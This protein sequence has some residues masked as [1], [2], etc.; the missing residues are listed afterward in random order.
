M[1]RN[2]FLIDFVNHRL[3][4]NFSSS[5]NI[6]ISSDIEILVSSCFSSCK[7][8]SSIS[9][10][11][12]SRLNRKN[13][14]HCHFHHFNRLSIDANHERFTMRSDFLID[15]LDH[16]LVALRNAGNGA[17]R[18]RPHPVYRKETFEMTLS[19]PDLLQHQSLRQNADFLETPLWFNPLR[20][21]ITGIAP[22]KPRP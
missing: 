19:R 7:S 3:I 21:G 13:H 22:N 8:L 18:C 6:R 5:S 12:D 14:L 11:P 4:R 2:D 10:E 16:R 17:N 1:M 15:F 20:L 9:F